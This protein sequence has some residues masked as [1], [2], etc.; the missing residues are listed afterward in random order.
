MNQLLKKHKLKLVI[1]GSLTLNFCHP[2]NS[3]LQNCAIQ[4]LVNDLKDAELCGAIGVV[5]HMGKNVKKLEID[6]QQ[7]IAN[8]VAGI[9][10]AIDDTKN[11]KHAKIIMETGAGQGTEVG[12][13]IEDLGELFR[14]FTIKEQKRPVMFFRRDTTWAVREWFLFWMII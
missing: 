7:A 8:Y 1:H 13:S 12:T 11:V 4:S 5:I 14:M 2:V 10:K 6:N 9:R 3:Y